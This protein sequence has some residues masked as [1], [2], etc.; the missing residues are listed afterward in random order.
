MKGQFT[1]YGIIFAFLGLILL[2]ALL[3]AVYTQIGSIV[4][5]ATAGGDSTT[6]TI[7]P[8]IPVVMVFCTLLIPVIYTL[9]GRSRGNEGEI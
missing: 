7:A 5:N 8:L 1:L 6:A 4:G 9:A 3:P 2:A